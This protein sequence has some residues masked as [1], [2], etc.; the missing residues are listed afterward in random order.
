MFYHLDLLYISFFF[1]LSISIWYGNDGLYV[2][3]HEKGI[4]FFVSNMKKNIFLSV[5]SVV[6]IV[7]HP[8]CNLILIE[9]FLTHFKFVFTSLFLL[10]K[11]TF[12]CYD[13]LCFLLSVW[14]FFLWLIIVLTFFFSSYQILFWC[15]NDGMHCD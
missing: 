3:H 2:I 5:V 4:I 11:L 7:L 12:Y 8:C 6:V 9:L 10:P 15:E 13:L 1:F 14:L